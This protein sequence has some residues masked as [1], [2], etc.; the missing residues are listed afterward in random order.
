LS[1]QALHQETPTKLQTQPW[2]VALLD[3]QST[4]TSY[5]KRRD[6]VCKFASMSGC[7]A[8]SCMKTRLPLTEHISSTPW[9]NLLKQIAN[10]TLALR[11]A[12]DAYGKSLG[13]IIVGT[14][15]VGSVHIHMQGIPH[16]S[17]CPTFT[18]AVACILQ[19]NLVRSASLINDFNTFPTH[20]KTSK[21]VKVWVANALFK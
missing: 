20:P 11:P 3:V 10:E 1:P 14:N 18:H 13:N 2:C 5:T 16:I 6:S 21:M 19:N 4:R 9:S 7:K 15:T 17:M 12:T 8:R